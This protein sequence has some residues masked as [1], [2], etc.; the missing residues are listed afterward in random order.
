MDRRNRILAGILLGAL[1]ILILVTGPA[2]DARN[3]ADPRVSTFRST[4]NGARALYL[5][6]DELGVPVGRWLYALADADTSP[7]VLALVAPTQAMTPHELNWLREWVEAGGTLFYVARAGAGIHD[8]L[9]LALEPHERHEDADP[10]RRPRSAVA[11]LTPVSHA[12]TDGIPPMRGRM[13]W[14]FADSSARIASGAAEP[15]LVTDNGDVGALTF[16]VGDGTVVAWSDYRAFTNEELRE[17]GALLL[18]ARAVEA[19]RHEDQ[20]LV[21]DEFHHGYRARRGPAWATLHFLRDSPLGHA[22]LQLIVAGAGVLVL[23][24]RRFGAPTPPARA[25]RRSPLEHVEA[26]AGAYRKANARRRIRH[27]VVAG[28]MRR[29]GRRPPATP[30]EERRLLETLAARDSAG[31]DAAGRLLDEWDKE[32]NAEPHVLAREA[33]RLMAEVKRRW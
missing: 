28:L 14:V 4:A 27:L 1:A 15:L 12:W 10:G 8:T 19:L 20:P 13:R 5:T 23:L 3:D 29:L 16:A 33:D 21:F 17:S 30:D 18:F 26:L 22:T 11:Q 25:D 31:S 7:G 9:G 2:R 32:S 6:L 24:G